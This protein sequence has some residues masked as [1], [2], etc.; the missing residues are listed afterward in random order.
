MQIRKQKQVQLEYYRRAAADF[1]GTRVNR[2]HRRKIE[3]ISGF[4]NIWPGETVLEV[5]IGTGIHAKWL[6]EMNAG[7]NINFLG[8]DLSPEMLKKASNKIGSFPG[9]KLFNCQAENLPLASQSVNK[10]YISGSLHHFGDPRKSIEELIRVVAPGGIIVIS[11][12]NIFNPLNF[13]LVLINIKTEAGQ[14]HTYPGGLR[15]IF[16]D[17]PVKIIKQKLF[18]ATP[19]FPLWTSNI[20]DKIDKLIEALPIVRN[21]CSMNLIV[22]KRI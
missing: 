17:L 20:F 7:K 13:I 9:V 10:A 8:C 1:D 4:L 19:P 3:L 6:L 2:C 15:R 21:L 5:G 16:R 11:E 22:V 18:N 14:F 12:P